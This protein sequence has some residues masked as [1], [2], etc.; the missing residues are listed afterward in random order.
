MNRITMP[1]KI[2]K[3]PNQLLRKKA[4]PVT[5]FPLDP[6]LI[7]QLQES[8]H[9]SENGV[10]LAAN[11]IGIDVHVFFISERVPYD[12]IYVNASYES[13]H[14]DD[15]VT[16]EEGCLSFP[17]L[18]LSLKRPL[19]IRVKYQTR[20]GEHKELVADGF[21]S[22]IIQHEVDH[23]SGV[24]FIDSLPKKEKALLIEKILSR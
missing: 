4:A 17:H 23:L 12:Q 3:Y 1:L 11:Q 14:K 24:L 10:A 15:A 20:T 18:R 6:A 19:W 9:A 2:I 8:L 22:R 16:M 21:L 7:S 5:E 13:I